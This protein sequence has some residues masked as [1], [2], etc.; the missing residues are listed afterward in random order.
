MYARS[1][2]EQ[3]RLLLRPELPDIAA[4]TRTAALDAW[5]E[6]LASAVAAE[7]ITDKQARQ[8]FNRETLKADRNAA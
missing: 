2:E 4:D 3:K 5:A 1:L 6:R 8:A 7:V